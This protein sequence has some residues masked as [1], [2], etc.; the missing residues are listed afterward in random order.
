[1]H[2]YV[3]AFV[4][5]AL[6]GA[7]TERRSLSLAL[8]L[9][10]STILVLFMGTRYYTGCD[11]IAYGLRFYRMY[12]G[13]PF[14]ELMLREEPGFHALNWL[15]HLFNLDYVWLNILASSIYVF[16]IMKF[17]KLA[18]RP[19]LLIA[20][21]FPILI[22]QLGMSGL[23]QALANGFLMMAF[24]AFTDRSRAKT[25]LW[26]LVATLFHQSAVILLPIALVANSKV[27][28]V[29]LV[30]ALAVLG[31]L[32]AVLLGDRAEVYS[33]RYVE[34]IYGEA[35]SSGAILRYAVALLPF[36]F[37]IVLRDKVR[38]LHPKTFELMRLF[39]II[40]FC[41]F[42]LVFVSTVALHRVVYYLL[43]VSTLTLLAVSEAMFP[44]KDKT[45]PVIFPI[46]VY[47]SYILVW[48]SISKHADKCY[49]PYESYWL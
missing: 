3:S 16:C 24:I 21:F 4:L 2:V 13:V 39:T 23:R 36:L 6:I 11:F 10:I 37:F 14:R 43:P 12:D 17:S 41:I 49:L 32:A 40:A 27:S 15:V 28:V 45:T 1:M 18:T 20:L 33:D 31:P 38:Q 25:A 29:R 30:L 48:F 44:K 7:N 46:T 22:V 42:P 9:C 19:L 5:L 47:G 26:I 35:S 34:Q 8:T